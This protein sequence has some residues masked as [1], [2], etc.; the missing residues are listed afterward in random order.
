MLVRVCLFVPTGI[1]D[2][3]RWEGAGALLVGLGIC[4]HKAQSLQSLGVG[5]RL[6]FHRGKLRLGRSGDLVKVTAHHC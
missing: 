4:W 3:G 2:V 6:L 1:I 5:E